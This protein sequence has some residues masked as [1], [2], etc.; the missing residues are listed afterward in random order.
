MFSARRQ[1]VGLVV[2]SRALPTRQRTKWV[3]SEG[4]QNGK[5]IEAKC[6]PVVSIQ[7]RRNINHSAVFAQFNA[8]FQYPQGLLDQ[9]AASQQPLQHAPPSAF[10]RF[11]FA[12]QGQGAPALPQRQAQ[13]GM[14]PG[15]PGLL[16][17]IAQMMMTQKRGQ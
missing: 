4:R 9:I 17:Q 15:L 12:R 16:G 14:N 2:L 11:N 1:S 7:Q 10:P 3:T 5:D 6:P 13:P 8:Q